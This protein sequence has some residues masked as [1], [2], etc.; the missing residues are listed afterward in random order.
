MFGSSFIEDL[1]MELLKIY[2]EIEQR[3]REF[4]AKTG[5]SCLRDCGECCAKGR[6][7]ITPLEFIP[8]AFELEKR[9]ELQKYLELLKGKEEGICVFY[10]PVSTDL[11]KGY[12]AFYEF[13][14]A[15]CR[16]YGFGFKRNKY[17]QYEPVTCEH[18]RMELLNIRREHLLR[19]LPPDYDSVMIRI[20]A[21]SPSFG[22]DK[23]PPNK[24]ISVALEKV[25]LFSFVR[26]AH[27]QYKNDSYHEKY[28]EGE[29]NSIE[30]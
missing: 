28:G 13:R 4:K 27:Y 16:L 21:L 15:T 26:S 2:D 17:G 25:G 3:V 19:I 10:R 29:K 11:K 6:I 5:I 23:Y 7:R 9:G 18:L 20:L 1:N 30:R 22:M 12:C 24:A 14:A 8:L